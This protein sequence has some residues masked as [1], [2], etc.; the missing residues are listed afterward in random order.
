MLL[1]FVP[2]C[3]SNTWSTKNVLRVLKNADKTLKY[4]E[5]HFLCESIDR[6]RHLIALCKL[7]ISRKTTEAIITIRYRTT[8]S[9]MRSFLG[10]C[11][12]Y[13]RFVLGFVKIAAAPNQGLRNGNFL[14]FE[15]NEDKRK[16]VNEQKGRLWAPLS[17]NRKGQ[18]GGSL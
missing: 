5:Y 3:C 1:S 9:K 11:Y 13:R 7:E 15:H 6:P 2:S 17:W 12:V 10:L 16:A 18:L 8:V 14:H 4:K